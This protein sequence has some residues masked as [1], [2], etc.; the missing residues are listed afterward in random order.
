MPGPEVLAVE[1]M[2]LSFW[3]DERIFIELVELVGTSSLVCDVEFSGRPSPVDCE[4]SD[5]V[6]TCCL[7][8]SGVVVVCEG[9]D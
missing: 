5:F 6:I 9:D 3:V 4:S 1:I 7:E 8:L 2:Y